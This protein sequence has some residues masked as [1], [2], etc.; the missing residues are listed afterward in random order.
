MPLRVSP[1][2]KPRATVP[3]VGQRQS[4]PATR[5]V[6]AVGIGAVLP[7]AVGGVARGSGFGSDRDSGGDSGSGDDGR[8]GGRTAASVRVAVSLG[9]R[10]GRRRA[11]GWPTRIVYGAAIPFQRATSRQ[12]RP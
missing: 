12:S 1:G 3:A 8:G 5:R 7:A 9:S 6:A 4:T 11:I 2:L 10:P